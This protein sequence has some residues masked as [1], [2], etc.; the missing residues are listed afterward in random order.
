MKKF[1]LF[2]IFV[3]VYYSDTTGQKVVHFIKK[4]S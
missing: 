4:T 2:S 1:G 3:V